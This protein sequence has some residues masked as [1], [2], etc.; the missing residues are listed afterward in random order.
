V[1]QP[2]KKSTD[3]DV[4]KGAQLFKQNC[5]SCHALDKILSGPALRGVTQRGPWAEDKENFRKWVKNPAAFIPTTQYTRHLHNQYGQ[6][7]PSF[8]QMTDE[9]LE[10]LYQYLSD[11]DL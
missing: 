4:S 2:S 1:R 8:S 10:W 5:A 9:E 3:P 7:M 6:I 11:S